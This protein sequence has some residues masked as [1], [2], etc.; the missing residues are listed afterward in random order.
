M[1]LQSMGH[2]KVAQNR[3]QQGAF[4]IPLMTPQVA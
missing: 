4:T 2:I 1:G 3:I